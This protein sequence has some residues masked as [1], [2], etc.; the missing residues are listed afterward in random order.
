ME[1]SANIFND[2]AFNYFR[3]KLYIRCLIWFWMHLWSTI[4]QN[5]SGRLFSLE[6]ILL[7][8]LFYAT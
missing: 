3:K 7:A 2:L 6:I 1:L 4:F 5:P 8:V